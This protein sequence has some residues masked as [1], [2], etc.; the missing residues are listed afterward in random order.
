MSVFTLATAWC[1]LAG[2]M[3]SFILAR[4]VCGLGAGGMMS[5][6][7]IIISDLVPIDR[8]GTYQSYVN[9]VYGVAS[10]SGAALGGVMADSLGWRWEFGIQ[11]IPEEKENDLRRYMVRLNSAAVEA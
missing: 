6:G 2:S 7:S 10:A 3:T 9:V 8:R 1:A 4:A 5:L 11:V